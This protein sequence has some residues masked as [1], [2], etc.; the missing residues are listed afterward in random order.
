MKIFLNVRSGSGL[1]GALL[2]SFVVS[3]AGCDDGEPCGPDQYLEGNYCKD[4][5]EESAGDGDG[6]T[7]TDVDAKG[8]AGGMDSGDADPELMGDGDMEETG[9]FGRACTSDDECA[10]PA[11]FCAKQPGQ[12]A[13]TCSVQGCATMGAQCPDGSTCLDFADVCI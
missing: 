8:G 1:F 12:D 13:G 4:S 7:D 11:P 6:D 3:V 10:E 2:I 5:P 9:E